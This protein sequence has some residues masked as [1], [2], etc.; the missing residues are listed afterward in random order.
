MD[1]VELRLTREQE[2]SFLEF[3]YMCLQAYDFAELNKRYGV[4]L[5]MGGSDQWGNIVTGV[6]LAGAWVSSRCTL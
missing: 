3:N 2:L 5:Q 4:T 6:D 1:W